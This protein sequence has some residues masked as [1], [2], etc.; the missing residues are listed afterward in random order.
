M[1]DAVPYEEFVSREYVDI[2]V[3]TASDKG[4][5][6]R[7]S[8]GGR[9]IQ[10]AITDDVFMEKMKKDGHFIVGARMQGVLECYMMPPRGHMSYEMTRV[11]RH[12]EPEDGIRHRDMM[13]TIGEDESGEYWALTDNDDA[14]VYTFRKDGH[15]QL[16]MT[17]PVHARP[18]ILAKIDYVENHFAVT[19]AAGVKTIGLNHNDKYDNIEHVIASIIFALQKAQLNDEIDP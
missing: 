5:K 12:Y 11:I 10:A 7:F 8:F 19:P 4:Y 3:M 1:F 2:A 18:A 6:W 13:L 15:Y 16:W 9:T 17:S 14:R